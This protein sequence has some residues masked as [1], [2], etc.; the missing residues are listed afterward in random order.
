MPVILFFA[1]NSSL[2]L[3]GLVIRNKNFQNGHL[4][5]TGGVDINCE[6]PK[7]GHMRNKNFSDYE[8]DKVA[9]DSISFRTNSKE[10]K[11]TSN[12]SI[13]QG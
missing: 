12:L 9:K 1:S 8:R 11:P 3:R 5:A 10:C 13:R 4:N 7:V 6:G 2:S